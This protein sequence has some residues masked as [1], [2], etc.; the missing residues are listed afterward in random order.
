MLEDV[1]NS[2]LNRGRSAAL[3]RP[4]ACPLPE[5]RASLRVTDQLDHSASKRSVRLRFGVLALARREEDPVCAVLD[6]RRHAHSVGE[7]H[8]GRAA[9]QRL[10]KDVAVGLAERRVDEDVGVTIKV[11][12]PSPGNLACENH[13]ILRAEVSRYLAVMFCL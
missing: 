12:H 6:L 11:G 8:R 4:L 10:A 9:P 2:L 3:A 5:P 7:S 13:S 1:R